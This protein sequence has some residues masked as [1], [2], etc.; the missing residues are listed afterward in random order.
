MTS[1]GASLSRQVVAVHVHAGCRRVRRSA[2]A[3]FYPV[4]RGAAQLSSQL[5]HAVAQRISYPRYF[6]RFSVKRIVDVR[7]SWLVLINH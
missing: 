7:V 4:Q 3:H 2:A 5:L 1:P 6:L